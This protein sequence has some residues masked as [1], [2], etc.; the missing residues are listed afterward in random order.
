MRKVALITILIVGLG[1]GTALAQGVYTIDTVHSNVNFKIRHLISKVGGEFNDFSGT[2]TA[3]FGNLNN[4]SVE[5]VIDAASIDTKNEDRDTHLRSEDFFDAE[6]FP[7]ITFTSHKITKIDDTTFAVTGN[8][9]MHGVTKKVTLTVEYLGE[10]VAMG[11]TRAGYELST[12][13]NRKDFD[14]IWNKT[15]DNGGLVL[16]DN[17]E[18]EIHLEVVK[19]EDEAET[20]NE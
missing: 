17:V 1:V 7:E 16:G 14:I 12:V 5:F 9:F 6:R 8:L 11:G 18:V 3:D 15:L 10:M 19:Q 2:I 4:S 13:L 20:N